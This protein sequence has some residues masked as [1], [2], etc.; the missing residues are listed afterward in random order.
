MKRVVVTGLGA[1]TPI[2]N[3]VKDYWEG[4][5]NGVSGAGD[6]TY[7]DTTNFKTKFA[8]QVKGFDPTDFMHRR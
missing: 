7:Y 3:T 5:C 1:I 2:G 6:I 4:L 8:C